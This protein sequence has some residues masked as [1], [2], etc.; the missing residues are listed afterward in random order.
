M[1]ARSLLGEAV[2]R[3]LAD[4]VPAQAAALAYYALFSLAPL[5]VIAIGVSGLVFGHDDAR[6]EILAQATALVGATG[7]SALETLM[8]SQ[9]SAPRSGAIST[10]VGFFA[11]LVGAAAVVG[12]LR[13]T[14]NTVWDVEAP[15]DETWAMTLR[16]QLTSF[17]LVVATGFLLLVSLVA[18]ATL[19]AA[20]AL[21]RQWLPGLGAVWFAAD[22]AA[23]LAMAGGVFALI[24]KT[25]PA[26]DVRW[27]DA[28]VGGLA[29]ALVFTIGRLLLGW[30][31]GGWGSTSAYGA[32]GSVL[33]FLV[34]V[35]YSAQ[36]VLF[37]AEF[38]FVY[39]RRRALRPSPAAQE[40][41]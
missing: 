8:G 17:A 18:S 22:A 13:A 36:L 7:A 15:D 12:Q 24:F 40:A 9:A 6:T 41:S 39:A 2:D 28:L 31:L 35:Y 34:W 16:K 5:L 4:R 23:G 11:L 29:T 1:T 27:S 38:T 14:L 32:A 33:A 20:S 26:A 25:M 3:W 37:G 21:A 10:I 30:Y 19:A